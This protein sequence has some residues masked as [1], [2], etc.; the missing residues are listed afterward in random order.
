MKFLLCRTAIIQTIGCFDDNETGRRLSGLSIQ[1]HNA[2]YSIMPSIHR[3][4]ADSPCTPAG[5]PHC[6]LTTL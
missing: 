5:V 6:P 4:S 3:H 1:F 2:K